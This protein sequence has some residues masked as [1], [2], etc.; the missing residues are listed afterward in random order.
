MRITVSFFKP[1]LAAAI[2][3]TLL[4]S[5]ID[6]PVVYDP[7]AGFGGRLLG[8]KSI[9]PNGK[10]IG[11]EINPETYNELK[12]LV[13]K[14]GFKDVELYNV[15]CQEFKLNEK[16]DLTFTS[17]PYFNLEVYSN[18]NLNLSFEE[19]ENSFIRYIESLP[20]CFINLNVELAKQLNWSTIHSKLIMN[21]S[22][23]NKSNN[24]K[25][26]VIVQV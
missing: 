15:P 24:Q 21:K 23:F 12:E 13:S 18:G 11:C 22:H 4:P 26:E 2:Y 1:L 17:I 8:F 5:N 20:N 7:C 14:C 6:S 9:Y 3:K 10:Y 25:F 16:V 19:W